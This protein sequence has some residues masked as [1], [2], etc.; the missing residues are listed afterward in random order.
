M[1]AAALKKNDRNPQTQ[2]SKTK[3]L[4]DSL[5]SSTFP[6]LTI[7]MPVRNE[8]RFIKTT[9]HQLLAQDYPQDRY[10]IIVADG[11][12]TDDTQQLVLEMAQRHAQVRL[13]ENPGRFPSSGR[14]LGFKNGRG[15]IFVVIDG[16]CYIPDHQYFKAIVF[17]FEKSHADCL[18]RPQPLDPPELTPFQEAVALARASRIG[19]SGDSF[20]YSL[21]EGFISP[22]SNG[23]AYKKEVFSKTGYVDERFDACEDVEF[24]YRVEK[25]GLKCYTSPEL[26]VRYYPRENKQGLFKQMNRYGQGRFKFIRK[27]PDSLDLNQF[28]P[29][30]WVC[31]LLFLLILGLWILN[32]RPTSF[33]SPI[34]MTFGG[35]SIIY[36]LYLLVILVESFRIGMNKGFRYVRFLSSIFLVIHF[37][38]GYGFLKEGVLSIG[39]TRKGSTQ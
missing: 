3:S 27:H 15:D 28:I 24:N 11:E 25:A 8:A 29:A 1:E 38:L 16:H 6:F 37:G 26:A 33:W 36:G 31:G 9:L 32:F 4:N 14:N 35:L 17:C 19:H 7:V 34:T 39:L 23:F 18:G 30:L 12:S 13:M 21:F 2:D 10:E 5:P 22:V 20:I